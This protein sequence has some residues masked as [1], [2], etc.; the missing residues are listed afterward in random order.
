MRVPTIGLYAALLMLPAWTASHGQS[1]QPGAGA[2]WVEDTINSQVLGPRII[3]VATPEGYDQGSSQYPVLVLLDANDHA[4]FQLWIAQ[5]AYLAGNSS[6]FPP[7]IAVGIVNGSDRIHDMTPPAT[8]S[9]VPDFPNAGGASAFADFIIGEALPFVR[10]RYR[11]LP[12]VILTGHSAGGLFALDVAAHRPTAFQGII[13]TSP[14]V[15]F[16]DG[17]LADTYADLLG[18]SR[19]HPRLFVSSG[20]DEETLAAATQRLVD[21]MGTYPS[22]RGTFSSRSYPDATHKL[23]PMSFGDGLRFIFDPVSFS[24]LAIE[25]LDFAKVDSVALN[26][27]IQSSAS[28]YAAAARSLGLAEP[29]PEDI[30]NGLGYRLLGNSKVAL[31]IA[32][33]QRNIRAYP[34]SVNVYDSLADGFLAAGDTTSALAQLR[35]AVEVAHGTGVRV[36]D[37]TQKKLE[38]L[39]ATR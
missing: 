15:W 1:V 2:G 9:S 29:L 37:E 5:A 24:H 21:R 34:K 25:R 32:V 39:E 23:T 22:L 33:F 35:T 14:A 36:P 26:T 19:S 20:G 16:N 17:V 18:R 31:A 3:Y 30:L 6:G 8:G 11:T 4:M 7:V 13:A 12:G 28:S 10:A 27:A 38:A